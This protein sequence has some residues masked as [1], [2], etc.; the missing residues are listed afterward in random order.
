[1]SIHWNFIAKLQ[2]FNVLKESFIEFSF[3]WILSLILTAF[4]LRRGEKTYILQFNWI[5]ILNSE[6]NK[7]L[8]GIVSINQKISTLK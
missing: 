3:S 8:M 6:N 7:N 2:N 1:M 5:N 4:E